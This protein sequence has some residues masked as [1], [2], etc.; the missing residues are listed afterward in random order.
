MLRVPHHV[1]GAYRPNLFIAA[2][3]R[4]D[5]ASRGAV[6]K[7]FASTSHDTL[8]LPEFLC[9]AGATRGSATAMTEEILRR[10]KVGG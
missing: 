1:T 5:L 4:K 3:S 2:Y 10:K 9:R 6:A 8:P 7:C